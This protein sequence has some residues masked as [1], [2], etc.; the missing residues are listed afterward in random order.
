MVSAP[1]ASGMSPQEYLIECRMQKALELLS[2][3]SA[4]IKEIAESAGFA[5]A[6]YFT[7]VFHRMF[8]R[9]PSELRALTLR[10]SV[11]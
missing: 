10:S 4:S 7:K 11:G 3:S 9:S 6:N 8:G 5:N 1:A 2:N